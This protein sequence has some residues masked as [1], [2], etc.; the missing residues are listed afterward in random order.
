[1]KYIRIVFMGITAHL[2]GMV[3]EPSQPVVSPLSQEITSPSAE[4]LKVTIEQAGEYSGHI[5]A[6]NG[7]VYGEWGSE[8]ITSIANKTMNGFCLANHLYLA[9]IAYVHLV[10][11]SNISPQKKDELVVRIRAAYKKEVA[12]ILQKLGFNNA[13]IKYAQDKVIP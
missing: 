5:V 3:W 13:V 8:F 7:K 9:F 1:M 10:R 2:S 6:L 4:Q 12:Y 11:T